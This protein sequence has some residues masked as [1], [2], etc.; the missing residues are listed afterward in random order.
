MRSYPF[1]RAARFP[2]MISSSDGALTLHFHPL[3]SFCQK[4]LIGLYE[5]GVPFQKNIV[6]LADA[7][8]RDALLALWPLGK[9]PVLRDERHALTLPET[10]IILE[11]VEACWARPGRLIPTDPDEARECR[12]RDRFFDLYVN[13]PMAT[14]VADKLRPDHQRDALG[15][16]RA[17]AEL[18]AAYGIADAWLRTGPWALGRA[19]SVADCAAAPALYYANRVMSFGQARPHL[20]EYFARLRERPSYARVF[21]E[22][23][24]YLAMFPG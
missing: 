5:L 18:E 20:A 10:T 4:V 14:I 1:G 6:D 9:F 17:K 8:Q 19:F 15:V 2:G 11:H 3:S 22:A 24:P 21:E 16:A 7:A 12:L 23:K 13:T